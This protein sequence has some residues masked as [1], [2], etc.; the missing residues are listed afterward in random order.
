MKLDVLGIIAF[1]LTPMLTL[2]YLMFVGYPTLSQSLLIITPIAILLAYNVGK[3][4]TN[5]G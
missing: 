1:G 3:G 4:L 2:A 5:N